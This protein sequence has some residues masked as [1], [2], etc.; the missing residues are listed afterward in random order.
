MRHRLAVVGVFAAAA[1]SITAC[2]SQTAG[3]AS[4][5]G[6]SSTSAGTSSSAA[7]AGG[8]ETV[9]W[10]DKVCGASLDVIKTLSTEPQLDTTD[11]AKMQTQFAAWL[12]DGSKAV[13]GAVGKLNDLKKGP[14]P[15]SEKLATAAADIFGQLKTALDKAKTGVE[16]ANPQDPASI[17]AAFTQVATDMQ[18]VAKVGEDFDG[19]LVRSNLADAEKKA[20]NCKAIEGASGSTSTPPTS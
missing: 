10:I 20:P 17:A 19:V 2:G 4:G 15:D 1:L 7:V 18:A 16:A 11:P 5:T 12:G 13:D 14:H 3:T 8:D 6:G 9:Q